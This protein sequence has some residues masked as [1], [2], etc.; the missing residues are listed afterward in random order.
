VILDIADKAHPQLVATGA[1]RRL[2][3]GF[4]HT[5]L[6]LFERGLL[7]VSDEC[8]YPDG[9]DWPKLVWV[10]DARLETNPVRSAPFRCRPWR[11]LQER[12]T[13]RRA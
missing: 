11:P 10:V 5:V 4:T 12:W 7:I 13:L 8:V 2:T 1:I 6:P 3:H 9:K